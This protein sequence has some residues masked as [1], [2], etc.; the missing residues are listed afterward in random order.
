MNLNEATEALVK[1]GRKFLKENYP[2]NNDMMHAI[3]MHGATSKEAA[4]YHETIKK[5]TNKAIIRKLGKIVMIKHRDKPDYT[6]VDYID[7]ISLFESKS[8]RGNRYLSMERVMDGMIFNN[9]VDLHVFH[10]DIEPDN[11][12]E[13]AVI[14]PIRGW[15]TI[16]S[17]TEKQYQAYKILGSTNKAYN[18]LPLSKAVVDQFIEDFNNGS[19]IDEIIIEYNQEYEIIGF[20]FL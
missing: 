10:P 17:D 1:A 19:E 7:Y 8:S 20:S 3:F 9:R 6:D 11:E 16:Y 4:E 12:T 5:S 18:V 14:E 2:N 13:P 15:T